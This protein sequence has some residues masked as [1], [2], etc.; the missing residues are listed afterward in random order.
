MKGEILDYTQDASIII[1]NQFILVTVSRLSAH[2]IEHLELI[3]WIS[4]VFHIRMCVTMAVF[5]E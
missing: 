5:D 4:R 2:Q 1:G 3:E